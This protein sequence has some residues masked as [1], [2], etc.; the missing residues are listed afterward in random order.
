MRCQRALKKAGVPR[1]RLYDL[2][3]TYASLL[4]AEG[5]PLTY[6]SAQLGHTNPVTT[7]RSYAR[8]I[9]ASGR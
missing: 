1:F 6:A 2:R 3:H 5:A 9:P 4:L 8:W 7:L